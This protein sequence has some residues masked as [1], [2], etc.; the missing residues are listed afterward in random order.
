MTFL[1]KPI[2]ALLAFIGMAA[3]HAQNWPD[4]PIR[5]LVPY[6]AGSATDL[7]ARVISEPLSK[8]LGQP[9]V[10]DNKPGA[11][12][13]LATAMAVKA[14]PDGYTLVLA[15]NAGLAASPG[16]L[17]DGVPYDPVTDLA[18][19]T[20]VGSVQYVWVTNND[21]KVSNA[22]E[23]IDYI[24]AH[25]RQMSY[26]SGN[27]GGITYGGFLKNHYT[28]DMVH[29][30]YKSTPPAIVDVIGGQV[31]VMMSDVASVSPMIRSGKVK[32]L[33]VPSAK[34]NPLLPDVPTFAEQG[35]VTPPDFSGW[36]T[37]AAPAGTPTT[38]LNRLNSELVKIL[39]T[40][41]V[42]AKLLQNGIIPNPGTREE[43]ARHVREQL[44]VWRRMIKELNL[45]GG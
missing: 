40:Q 43:A 13:T 30:P 6:T 41:E 3:V 17:T 12:S 35:L 1:I 21:I 19:V 33:G 42:S 31:Q 23:M 20:L 34:R 4:K 9:I 18:Y 15:T 28:L 11:N 24:K 7:I 29:A 25:P 14:V 36:W 26:A 32:A 45:R 8:A 16:G 5:L 37:I 39:Q 2:L 38:V 22:K 44:D 27:T 10:I